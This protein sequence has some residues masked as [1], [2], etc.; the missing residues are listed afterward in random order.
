M[1]DTYS[2]DVITMCRQIVE[3]HGD[4]GI[5]GTGAWLLG[6]LYLSACGVTESRASGKYMHVLVYSVWCVSII[7]PDAGKVCC[8][9][10]R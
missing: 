8:C 9:N 10:P 3:S 2:G 5:Q 1:K 7:Y 4:L 6:H